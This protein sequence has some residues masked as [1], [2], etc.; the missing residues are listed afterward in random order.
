MR[1]LLRNTTKLWYVNAAI[2]A[3]EL[4]LDGN[5]T[6]EKTKS[7]SA[8]QIIFMNIYPSNGNVVERIFGKDSSFDMVATSNQIKLEVDTLLFLKDPNFNSN[9]DLNYDFRID[10]IRTSLNTTQYGLKKRT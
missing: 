5:Y 2:L 4:D 9:Y 1:D 8:P 7:Y 6:G 3:D 10:T